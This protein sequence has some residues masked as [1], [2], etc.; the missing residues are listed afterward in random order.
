M[1]PFPPLRRGFTLVELLVSIGIMGILIT[2]T[3]VAINPTK[4]L[5]DA[6]NT[7]RKFD[8]NT[9]L[10]AFGQYAIDGEGSFQPGTV[11]GSP[12]LDACKITATP[13]KLCKASTP[14]G[15]GTGQCA[16]AAVSCAW[17]QHLNGTFI[18][19]IPSDPRDDESG[20]EEQA[21]VDYRVSSQAPGR[22]RVESLN[23]ENGAVIEAVR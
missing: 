13:K 5:A 20:A 6:R 12:L 9:L 15:T 4:Q 22:L 19:S 14:H 1:R 7:Q 21:M 10:N 17:S 8:V 2:I 11:D 23:A 16:H 18:A 3:I